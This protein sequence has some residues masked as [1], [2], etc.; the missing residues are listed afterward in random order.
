MRLLALVFILFSSLQMSAQGSAFGIKGG[1]TL[2][3]Q[4]WNGRESE[5]LLRYHGVAYIESYNEDSPFALFAQAGYHVR[6]GATRI[7]GGVFTDP[8]GRPFNF[9]TTSYPYEFRNAA[10]SIGAKQKFPLA[11]SDAKA[12]YLLGVRVEYTINTNLNEYH[13]EGDPFLAVNLI[14]P[15][16]ELTRH[17]NYGVIAGGGIEFMFADLVGCLLEVN[18]SP[19]LSQQ[20]FQ[21]ETP[22]NDPFTGNQ[23]VLGAREIRNVSL[24]LSL[25]LRFLR[26]VEYVDFVY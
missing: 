4:Q 13:P 15:F 7:R 3:F 17:W 12:Y 2:G 20:Y 9:N 19:D 8:N 5:L 16:D 11:T 18:I 1:A 14:H 25:G 6:G 21:A 22:Y 24:E 23:R 26:I 10:L